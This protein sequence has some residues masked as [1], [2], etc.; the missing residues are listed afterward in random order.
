MKI[1]HLFSS[2]PNNYQPYNKLLI[3]ELKKYGHII[4]LFSLSASTN[5]V[6]G[7]VYLL[8]NLTSINKIYSL[9]F[10][11]NRLYKYKN[12]LGLNW[13]IAIYNFT[14]YKSLLDYKEY[15]FH[16][17]HIQMVHGMFLEFLICFN[18]KY[19]L[20]IRGS[21]VTISLINDELQREKVTQALHHSQR[22]HTI[23]QYLKDVVINLGVHND[24]I[25]V[26][27]R[28]AD[29]VQSRNNNTL[30]NKLHLLTVARF[31]WIKGYSYILEACNELKK[32][33]IQ[34]HYIICGSNDRN[35]DQY[36]INE[37]QHLHYLISLYGLNNNVELLGYVNQKNLE[38]QYRESDIFICGSLNEGLNTSI[39]KALQF[40]KIVVAPNVGAIPEYISDKINGLLFNPG[41]SRDLLDCLLMIIN[42]DWKPSIF[43]PD[44]YPS[45]KAILEQYNQ[46]YSNLNI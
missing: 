21:D 17:H 10:D 15:I 20:T 24:K 40:N 32:K 27:P 43:L 37:E 19:C 3:D 39:I 31:H 8:D 26:M 18:I 4:K 11:F 30:H 12:S 44:N 13:K 28:L 5:P 38:D 7:V 23:S 9:F 1:A 2:Y 45:N 22:I 6:K 36:L 42:K 16:I 41:E 14:R 29:K 35:M 25:S 46:F 34:F 33:G